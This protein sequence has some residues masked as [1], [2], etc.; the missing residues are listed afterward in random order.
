[1]RKAAENKKINNIYY[2]VDI[3][4]RCGDISDVDRHRYK[5]I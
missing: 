4:Y 2:Y 3:D 1:M 5:H